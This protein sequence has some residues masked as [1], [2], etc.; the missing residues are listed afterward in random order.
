MDVETVC[1]LSKRKPDTYV[2]LSLHMEDYY[3][4]MDA[5]EGA[6]IE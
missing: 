3:R 4:S 1:L 2:K 6:K 5:E